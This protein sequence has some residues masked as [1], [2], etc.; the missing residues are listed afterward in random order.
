MHGH[1]TPGGTLTTATTEEATVSTSVA[2]APRRT[3]WLGLITTGALLVVTA[4]LTGPASAAADGPCWD[5][6]YRG[7]YAKASSIAF[8][9]RLSAGTSLFS[10]RSV[11]RRPNTG[12]HSFLASPSG[13]YLLAMQDDSNLVLYL[14]R[15][16]G[17][18]NC[19][20]G[21]YD[22]VYDK[23]SALWSSGSVNWYD[24]A[25]RTT[26]QTDGNLVTY[27]CSAAL[28]ASGTDGEYSTAYRLEVQDDANVVIYQGT[29]PIW[30]RYNGAL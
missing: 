17:Y 13:H 20:A 1:H 10:P 5:P 12:L 6:E 11:A 29:Q 27:C 16:E 24:V 2:P 23:L 14:I 8:G 15:A 18:A 25:A 3:P 22:F 21:P 26:M 7:S 30:D 28:W 9:G 4:M 19:G